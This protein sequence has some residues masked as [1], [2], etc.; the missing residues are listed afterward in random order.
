MGWPKL[1][2]LVRHGESVGNVR[3][4]DERAEFPAAT[5]ELCL[6]ERG[7]EQ[8]RATAEYLRREFPPFDV[9]YVSYYE[10]AKQTM[11]ILCPDE[12]V[13]EDPRLTE[14]QRGIWHVMTHA[15]ILEQYPF[16]VKR[17]EREGY[18][19]YRPPGGENWADVEL[20]IH[21]FL[22]TLSRDYE[23]KNVLMVVH[24]HWLILFQ[25]LIHHFS[26]E[27]AVRRY[28]EAQVKNA[29]V[30]AYRGERDEQGRSRLVLDRENAAP[31][32]GKF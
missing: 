10:R 19:H 22:G 5:H 31:W 26:I 14:A 1:L 2:V 24:A 4:A 32:E 13:Y 23:D 3:T 17:K 16:E 28:S 9:R 8:A 15:Q 20:R 29:S 30:T 25:R 11:N 18:Y 27:E 6:T 12:R 7:C 21:S